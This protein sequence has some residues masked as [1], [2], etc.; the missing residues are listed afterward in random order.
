MKRMPG[1]ATGRSL[2]WDGVCGLAT[3]GLASS[4]TLSFV[5][6]IDV[7]RAV[8]PCIVLPT[9]DNAWQITAVL[10]R[11]GYPL[12]GGRDCFVVSSTSTIPSTRKESD[13]S[14]RYVA[15]PTE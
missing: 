8:R 14:E 10:R 1:W 3:A 9:P 4:L 12:P 15:P 2:I 6:N 5:W 11:G 7:P 13:G